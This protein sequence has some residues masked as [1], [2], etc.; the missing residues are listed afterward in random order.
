MTDL[1]KSIEI[2]SPKLNEM[3]K[4]H[5]VIIELVFLLINPP[6]DGYDSLYYSNHLTE[7]ENYDFATKVLLKLRYEPQDIEI[8]KKWTKDN[9]GKI[10]NPQLLNEFS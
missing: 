10:G 4:K 2:L 5:P 8:A 9:L 1:E 6:V 3:S 7:L